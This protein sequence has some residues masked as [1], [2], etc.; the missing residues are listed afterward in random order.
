MNNKHRNQRSTQP[1]TTDWQAWS[2]PPTANATEPVRPQPNRRVRTH[3]IKTIKWCN[4]HEGF[5]T[6]PK[7]FRSKRHLLFPPHQKGKK[8]AP[9]DIST[10][11]DNMRYIFTK[12]EIHPASDATC[13]ICKGWLPPEHVVGLSNRIDRAEVMLANDEAFAIELEIAQ[14]E[15]DFLSLRIHGVDA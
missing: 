14:L 13:G 8:K 7:K 9:V 12:M 4:G 15:T 1:N 11:L 6:L 2:K 5:H 10:M 3:R